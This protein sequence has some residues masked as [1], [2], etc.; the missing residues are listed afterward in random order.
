[1]PSLQRRQLIP[2]AREQCSDLV[3]GGRRASGR[4]YAERLGIKSPA[5]NQL[6]LVCA[7]ALSGRELPQLNAVLNAHLYLLRATA[8]P[9]VLGY[10]HLRHRA[11]LLNDEMHDDLAGERRIGTQS[12]FRV[13]VLE[14]LLP[15]PDD[16][17]QHC[18]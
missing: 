15:L 6:N 11:I 18:G 4:G 8:R 5:E 7:R 16:V 1:M 9:V 3:A 2:R 17:S 12:E 14:Q 13:A 10:G